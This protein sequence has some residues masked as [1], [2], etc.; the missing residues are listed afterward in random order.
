MDNLLAEGKCEEMLVVMNCGYT[1]YEKENGL[2]DFKSIGDVIAYDCVPFIDGK[3]RT[4]TDKFSRAVAGLSA[5]GGH[6]REIVLEHLDL[7]GNLGLFSSGFSFKTGKV[8]LTEQFNTP[9][10]FHKEIKYMFVGS[11]EMEGMFARYG[12]T[13]NGYIEKGYNIESYLHPHGYH[14]WDVWRYCCRNMA[15]KLFK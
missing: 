15:M 3:F 12:E 14:E 13:L 9:E 6:A 11:G 5:G 7:F 10:A 4:K 8:D 2:Y 1:Y